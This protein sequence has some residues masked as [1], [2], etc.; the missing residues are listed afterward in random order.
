MGKVGLTIHTYN[1]F[2]YSHK[3]K[4]YSQ[5]ESVLS[6]IISARVPMQKKSHYLKTPTV[7][8]SQYFYLLTP[9]GNFMYP[10]LVSQSTRI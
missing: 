10:N 6:F 4:T 3:V 1:I 2:N 8:L 7:Y 9:E 5:N